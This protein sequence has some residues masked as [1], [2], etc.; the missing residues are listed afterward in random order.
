VRT[1]GIVVKRDRE[2]AIALARTLVDRLA[3]RQLV[4]L[5]EAERAAAIGA[6]TAASTEDIIAQ[7][8]LIVVLGGDGTLLRVA[9]LMRH[10]AVPILGVNLGGLGFLT[11]VTTEE[12]MPMIDC[13][14]AGKFRLDLRMTLGV[15]LQRADSVLAERLV[16][17]EAVI[18]KGALARIIDLD[19]TVND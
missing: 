11:A 1:V 6:G 16:L 18:T 10:R 15:T 13:V 3:G 8:D 17:N 9:R 2:Q 4:P 14:L 5:V 19:T 7:A 12:L